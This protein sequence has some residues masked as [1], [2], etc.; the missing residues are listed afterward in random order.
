MNDALLAFA[1]Q[2]SKMSIGCSMQ[3]TGSNQFKEIFLGANFSKKLQKNIQFGIQFEWQRRSIKSTYNNQQML[4]GVGSVF[5]LSENLKTG[6][7]IKKLLTISSTNKENS[8]QYVDVIGGLT[9]QLSKQFYV[10]LDCIKQSNVPALMRIQFNYDIS[11]SISCKYAFE[12]DTGT[13]FWGFG[14][15]WK[16]IQ[17]C[18]NIGYHPQLGAYPGLSIISTHNKRL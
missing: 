2:N 13:Q 12:S 10:A 15:D 1:L 4:I 14:F 8:T 9:Y 17:V 18:T 16:K 11:K 5:N 3:Q 7:S 6:I